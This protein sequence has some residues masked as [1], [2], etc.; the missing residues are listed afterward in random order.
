ML[1]KSLIFGSAALLLTALIALTGCPTDSSDSGSSSQSQGTNYVYGATTPGGVQ[2]AVNA[3]IASGRTVVITDGTVIFDDNNPGIGIIDFGTASVRIA[4]VVTTRG[5]KGLIINASK[6]SVSW[7]DIGKIQLENPNDAYIYRYGDTTLDLTKFK[8]AGKG[9]RVPFI[10]ELTQITG[11]DEGVAVGAYTVGANFAEFPEQVRNL[12]VTDKLTVSS[13]SKKPA[14]A[15][16]RKIYALGL[17]DIVDNPLSGFFLPVDPADSANDQ[18]GYIVSSATLTSS[19]G[20]VEV[21][22]PAET[23]VSGVKAELNKNVTISPDS[24][25]TVA[26]GIGKVEG[27]G[28]VTLGN[29]VVAIGTINISEI[30]ADGRVLV[31]NSPT[32]PL[33]QASILIPNPAA[34]NISGYLAANSGNKG[35][36]TFANNSEFK[37]F[38]VKGPGKVAFDGTVSFVYVEEETGDISNGNKRTT[39]NIEND[40]TFKKTVTSKSANTTVAFGGNVT[41]SGA[42]TG[43]T[44]PYT[45]DGSTVTFGGAGSA[46]PSPHTLNVITLATGKQISI[47]AQPILEA[48]EKVTLTGTSNS[49]AVE[50]RPN[51]LAIAIDEESEEDVIRTYRTLGVQT[52]TTS[53]NTSFDITTGILKVLKGTLS[54][55]ANVTVNVVGSLVLDSADIDLAENNTNPGTVVIGN[56]T[57]KAPSG[58]DTVRVSSD[59]GEEAGANDT[60]VV[61]LKPDRISGDSLTAALIPSSDSTTNATIKVAS[62]KALT[63][64][65]VTLNLTASGQLIAGGSDPSRILLLGGSNPGRLTLSEAEE[66]YI[67]ESRAITQTSGSTTIV[68]TLS[69][70]DVVITTSGETSGIIGSIA[71]G[72]KDDAIITTSGTSD[73]TFSSSNSSF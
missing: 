73:V 66:T 69:G 59:L 31:N 46:S 3:G 1:K 39:H 53:T 7:G 65:G 60:S 44:S 24:G 21:N 30:A 15:P 52:G 51:S 71:G 22:V 37:N 10:T 63:I 20:A 56:T 28:L 49:V 16:I 19:T 33:P 25:S 43:T 61:T 57:I 9:L 35:T 17:L 18:G 64:S 8:I 2:A 4:G 11:N 72:S 67:G 5:A 40:V 50:L 23:V 48:V 12:Y 54:L 14:A 42:Y 27:P 70:D 58:S 47:G 38:Q 6:A 34:T 41:L 62:T 32:T 13:T 36:L 68:A 26:I 29:G 45:Y 55:G